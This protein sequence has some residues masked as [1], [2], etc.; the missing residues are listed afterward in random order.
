MHYIPQKHLLYFAFRNVMAY[1]NIHQR[2]IAKIISPEAKDYD[3][4]RKE[5]STRL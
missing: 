5:C 4:T 2:A 1:I 3:F